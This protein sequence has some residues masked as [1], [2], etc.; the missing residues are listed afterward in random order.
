MRLGRHWELLGELESILL[1][2]PL[3]EGICAHY[4]L[5]AYRCG[6]AHRGLQ[7][8]ADLRRSL[9]DELGIEPGS[10]CRELQRQILAGDPELDGPT[11][12]VAG[13]DLVASRM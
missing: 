11:A 12:T 6:K 5:A 9:V 2:N 10:A 4:M 3:D 13:T 1:A 7:A 8:Y